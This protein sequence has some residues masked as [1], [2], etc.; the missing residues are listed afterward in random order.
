MPSM[1][2]PKAIQRRTSKN[3]WI[4]KKVPADLRPLVGKREI[5]ASL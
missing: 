5:W 1:K 3:Y 2:I 4:R